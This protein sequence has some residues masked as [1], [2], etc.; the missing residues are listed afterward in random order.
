MFMRLFISVTLGLT[1]LINASAA[2][3]PYF[4]DHFTSVNPHRWSVDSTAPLSGFLIRPYRHGDETRGELRTENRLTLVT[5]SK[6][7][8]G[9]HV[10]VR[11]TYED[12]GNPLYVN[13]CVILMRTTGVVSQK[14]SWEV[15]DGLRLRVKYG[16]GQVTLEYA[17]SITGKVTGLAV[18]FVRANDLKEGLKLVDNP[19]E[20]KVPQIAPGNSGANWYTVE[21]VDNPKAGTVEAFMTWHRKDG[22]GTKE[23][24]EKVLSVTYAQAAEKKCVIPH[25]PGTKVA[26]SSRE[27]IAGKLQVSFTREVKIEPVK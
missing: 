20:Y 11:T 14:R 1:G 10:S 8:K 13:Q 23:N 6:F 16:H 21:M 25:F 26:I 9:A 27:F 3:E 7:P 5:K 24:R 22:E 17:D 12:T 4:T 15:S 2:E 19:K 18:A